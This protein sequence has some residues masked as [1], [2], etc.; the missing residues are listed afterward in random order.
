MNYIVLCNTGQRLRQKF[1]HRAKPYALILK[2]KSPVWQRMCQ[3]AV[4]TV[5]SVIGR[6]ERD[7][8][9]QCRVVALQIPWNTPWNILK[10]FMFIIQGVNL[11]QILDWR[12]YSAISTMKGNSVT[13]DFYELPNR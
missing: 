7:Q 9:E 2:G 5:L 8:S 6:G 12:A 10:D 1:G 13:L 3:P 11:K 4:D